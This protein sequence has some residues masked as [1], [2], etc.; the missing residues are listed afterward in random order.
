MIF[1]FV[2]LTLTQI[3]L[4][5]VYY[6]VGLEILFTN[7]LISNLI[8]KTITDQSVTDFQ[9]KFEPQQQI[10][11]INIFPIFLFIRETFPPSA[12]SFIYDNAIA[13]Q[14]NFPRLVDN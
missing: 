11:L 2:L 12:T 13:Q 14:E 8:L 6:L 7:K 10:Q 9:I 1:Y 5:I 3:W 4:V